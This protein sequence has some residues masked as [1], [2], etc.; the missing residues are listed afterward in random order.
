MNLCAEF[1]VSRPRNLVCALLP[2]FIL[3]YILKI[4]MYITILLY[5]Y[6][7]NIGN[8]FLLNRSIF[9]GNILYQRYFDKPP[10]YAPI[11][12]LNGT[13]SVVDLVFLQV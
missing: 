10:F 6:I 3:L 8:F 13:E 11:L 4:L 7:D 2:Q 12:L 5:F 9:F 1:Q